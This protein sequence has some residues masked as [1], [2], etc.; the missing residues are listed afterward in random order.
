M[1]VLKIARRRYKNL[2]TFK[3]I[4]ERRN[5][6]SVMIKLTKEKE[7]IKEDIEISFGTYYWEDSH[8]DSY[9]III[10]EN[11]DFENYV[12]FKMERVMN[13][14]NIWGIK[15][16]LDYCDTEDLPYVF[17]QFIFGGKKNQI[18][19]EEFN[20]QKQEVIKRLL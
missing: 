7:V 19:E 3:K 12:D 11:E 16:E 15:I 4:S 6:K 13:S 17:K 8:L 14:G 9:K 5:R 2:K 18:T 10:Y 20:Q 1:M